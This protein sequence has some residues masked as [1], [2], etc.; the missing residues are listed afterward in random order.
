MILYS[1]TA[2]CIAFFLV[3]CLKWH[4]IIKVPVPGYDGEG[5]C[6]ITKYPMNVKPFKCTLCLSGWIGLLLGLIKGYGWESILML[7]VAGVMGLIIDNGIKR[8]L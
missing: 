6:E 8:Y 4:K 2:A 1:F 7:F 5:F 3:E